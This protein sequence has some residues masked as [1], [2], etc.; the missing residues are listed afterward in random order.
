MPFLH[1]SVPLL[2][3]AYALRDDLLIVGSVSVSSSSPPRS[4]LC[5]VHG[6]PNAQPDQVYAGGKTPPPQRE[7]GQANVSICL[8]AGQVWR[9]WS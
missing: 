5:S 8:P 7:G 6:P 4:V 9:R 2:I 1:K 3:P